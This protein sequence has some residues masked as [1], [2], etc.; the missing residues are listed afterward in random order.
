[1]LAVLIDLAG[2]APQHRYHEPRIG[3]SEQK[4]F[5]LLFVLRINREIGVGANKIV[6]VRTLALDTR[7]RKSTP[8]H[9]NKGR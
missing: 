2:N 6:G 8:K 4:V 9:G 7:V 3:S 1:M 5:G